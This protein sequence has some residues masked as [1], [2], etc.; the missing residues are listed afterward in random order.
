[1]PHKNLPWH[2]PLANDLRFHRL[3][4]DGTSDFF[5]G[6]LRP[7]DRK[8]LVTS[9]ESWHWPLANDLRFHRLEADAPSDLF[10]GM[11]RPFDR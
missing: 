4:A 6:M 2:W 8:N 11:L 3:D 9:S 10:A 5:A 1:M 7:F